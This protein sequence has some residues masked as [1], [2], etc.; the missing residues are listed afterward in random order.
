MISKQYFVNLCLG[1]FKGVQIFDQPWRNIYS[2][3]N[4]I[5]KRPELFRPLKRAVQL[6]TYEWFS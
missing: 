3:R 1:Y 5:V 6:Q 4:H 2:C